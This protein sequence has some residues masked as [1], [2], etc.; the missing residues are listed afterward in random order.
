MS[1]FGGLPDIFVGVFGRP[2][3]IVP[4]SGGPI[5]VNGIF[6]DRPEDELGVTQPGA[7]LHL[8]EVDAGA[9]VNGVHIQI[10]TDWY[11]ARTPRPDGEGMTEIRLEVSNAPI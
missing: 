3:T 11:R 9:V 4:T 5:Q 8:R 6:S 7:V 10:G 2:V 1:L